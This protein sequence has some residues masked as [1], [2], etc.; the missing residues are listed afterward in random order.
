MFI[1]MYGQIP[2]VLLL[3]AISMAGYIN[4]LCSSAFLNIVALTGVSYAEIF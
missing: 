3:A 1:I 2:L 4:Y